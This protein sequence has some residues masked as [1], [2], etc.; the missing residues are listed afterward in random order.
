MSLKA[1]LIPCLDVKDGR[2]VKGVK[3]VN[4]RDAGDPVEI[5]RAYD[6]AGADELCFLDITA[7]HE[8]RGIICDV[9]ERT[10]EHCFMP[11][12][13]GGG[14]RALED[15]R[16][17]LL[18][19]ADKV[20][21]NTAAVADRKFVREAAKK[22][23][24]QS[25]VVAIDAKRVGEGRWEIFTHGGRRPTGIDA[26]AYARE[27][28]CLGAGELL[29]TSMDRDGT[30]KGFDTALTRA[31]ADTVSVPVIASGGAG[32]LDHLVD[33]IR[34]GGAS[35]VL[36]ASIFHFGTYALRDAKRY[37]AEHGIPMRLT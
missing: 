30:G 29:V 12:T 27:A 32:T 21:I 25:I 18:A 13:V 16:R 2:V 3:F 7:S 9:V 37:M 34:V 23:G 1:R 28:Q 17:L 20:S 14:I 4:L 6:E 22:F 5:A 26:I 8:D 36:A 24:S 31:I 15:I 10:A 11:L 35:A 19:G 33:A